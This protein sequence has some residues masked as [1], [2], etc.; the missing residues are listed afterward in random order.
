[1]TKG[2]R[3]VVLIPL[4]IFFESIFRWLSHFCE[5]EWGLSGDFYFG[6]G[7][8]KCC[9]S[10]GAGLVKIAEKLP[11][12]WKTWLD[13]SLTWK[14]TTYWLGNKLQLDL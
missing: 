9:V 12:K 8:L 6:W 4:K 14:L 13:S 3:V 1:M 10:F 7:D 5:C 2:I 11:R